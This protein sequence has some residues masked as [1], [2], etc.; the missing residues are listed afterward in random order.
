METKDAEFL[1]KLL[2]M[3]KIEAR[4]HLHVISS[5]LTQIGERRSEQIRLRSSRP[6]TGRPIP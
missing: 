1:K 2:A 5:E 6:C 4:E 3:F